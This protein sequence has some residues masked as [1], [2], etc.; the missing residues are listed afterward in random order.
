MQAA[1]T[2]FQGV[3][4]Q[5]SGWSEEVRDPDGARSR[6]AAPSCT[7]E[8]REA[9]HAAEQDPLGPLPW[10]FVFRASNWWE[11]PR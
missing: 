4:V 6:A 10:E 3:W 7:K 1:R 5:A 11:T 8:P 2:S 9:V